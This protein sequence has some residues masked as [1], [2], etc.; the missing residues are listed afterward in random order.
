MRRI[1]YRGGDGT[2][3]DSLT[4]EDIPALLTLPDG[5]LWIDLADEPAETCAPLLSQIFHFHPLAIDDA[6][7]ESHVP[8]VDDWRRIS[9]WCSTG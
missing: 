7:Q 8:K 4:M 1:L 3:N 5:L 2:L 9:T 6:L